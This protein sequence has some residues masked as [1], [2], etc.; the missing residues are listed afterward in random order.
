MSFASCVASAHL[1]NVIATGKTQVR[2]RAQDFS[3][4]HWKATFDT[5]GAGTPDIKD[6]DIPV[7]VGLMAWPPM[8]TKTGFI[9]LG[10]TVEG[11]ICPSGRPIVYSG[12]VSTAYPTPVTREGA[13]FP[14]QEPGKTINF[15]AFW[16]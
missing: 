9:F 12:I 5:V 16:E 10:W 1:P 6:I 8:P 15:K 7:N 13:P 3:A 14:A 11:L 2:P 4:T